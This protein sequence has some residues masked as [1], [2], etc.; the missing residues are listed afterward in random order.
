ML[1]LS[2][3]KLDP[4]VQFLNV[5][6][7]LDRFINNSNNKYVIYAKTVY[8]SHSKSRQIGP[9]FKWSNIQMSKTVF[10]FFKV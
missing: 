8:A 7:S 6:T 1:V 2:T 5:K 3:W 10:D 9:V 4:F